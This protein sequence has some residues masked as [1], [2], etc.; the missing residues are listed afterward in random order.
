MRA[1]VRG[2]IARGARLAEPGE[3]TQ[4]AYLNGKMDLTQAE[5]V[6][7]LISAQT[8]LALRAA[9]LPGVELVLPVIANTYL[10]DAGV[11]ASRLLRPTT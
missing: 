4:R 1:I 2:A 9:T 7:D 10:R 5:A 8:D 11:A 6:M 3:F